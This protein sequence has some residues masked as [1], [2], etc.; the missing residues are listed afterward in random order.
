M[1]PGNNNELSSHDDQTDASDNY[2]VGYRE[3]LVLSA[4]R[5]ALSGKPRLLAVL[6]TIMRYESESLQGQ[7]DANLNLAAEDEAILADFFARQQVAQNS[8]EGGENDVG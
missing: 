8:S 7:A 6:P 3:A 5:Q 1:S 2:D 4:V